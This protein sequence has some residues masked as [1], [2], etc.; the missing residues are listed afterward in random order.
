MMGRM[1]PAR[2]RYIAVAVLV[3]TVSPYAH[4]ADTSAFG[5]NDPFV[6]ALQLWTTVFTSIDSLA[7]QLSSAL[8][9]HQASTAKP[10]APKTLQ[11]PA[12]LAAAAALATAFPPE[13]ATTSASQPE[14]TITSQQQPASNSPEEATSYQTTQS[15]F[16][17]SAEFSPQPTISAT[18]ATNFV[19]QAQFNAA[20]SLL[21]ASVQQ[22]LA[23]TDTNPFPEY[24]GADGISLF[25]SWVSVM[26]CPWKPRQRLLV[27][28]SA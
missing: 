17:K 20:L 24:V 4:A 23:K 7:H 15:P 22:L 5:R 19:T 16:V 6:D 21:G 18:P 28:S 13:T 26:A 10:H 2:G 3:L 1:P 12:A 14:T 11:Q 8:Q 9:L 27:R 25:S